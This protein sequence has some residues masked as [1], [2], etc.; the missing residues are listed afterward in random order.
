[1]ISLLNSKDFKFFEK[2]IN[3]YPIL[4]KILSEFM[5]Y[6]NKYTFNNVYILK[7]N[8]NIKGCFCTYNKLALLCLFDLKFL[9]DI[10]KFL[11]FKNISFFILNEDLG[12]KNKKNYLNLM[13]FYSPTKLYD[14]IDI[15]KNFK[16]TLN[17]NLKDTFSLIKNM[18]PKIDFNTFY[19]NINHKIRHKVYNIYNLYNHLNE[20]IATL[21]EVLF[22]NQFSFVENL[23]VNQIYSNQNLGSFLLDYL[24]TSNK[25]IYLLCDDNVKGFYLKNNFELKNK[26]VKYEVI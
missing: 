2:K 18:Y 16:L 24:K 5:A 26:Y 11:K 4:I 17:E 21:Q 9:N 8:N 23:Y 7:E 20:P 12:N 13:S 10:L 3:D 19:V 15:F 1:M 14:N 25:T 6:E 22:L